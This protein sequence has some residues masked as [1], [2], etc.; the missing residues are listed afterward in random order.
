MEQFREVNGNGRSPD[1]INIT[2]NDRVIDVNTTGVFFT[3]KAP[4]RQMAHFNNRGSNIRVDVHY[5]QPRLKMNLGTYYRTMGSLH[6]VQVSCVADGSQ[7][8]SG[9]VTR[10]FMAP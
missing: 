2:V 1:Q 9:R 8:G 4:E 6:L 10:S 7:H 3:A 5:E